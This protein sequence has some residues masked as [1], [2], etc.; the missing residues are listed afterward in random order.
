MRSPILV[1][2][3]LLASLL[4][5]VAMAANCDS[6]NPNYLPQQTVHIFIP[7]VPQVTFDTSGCVTGD[8]DNET[9]FWAAQFPETRQGACDPP[10]PW[11]G[12]HNGG[13]GATATILSNT[14]N[15]PV[16]Y[17]F[18]TDGQ[19][20]AAWAAGVGCTSNGI[21][22]DSYD[23]DPF[24]CGQGITGHFP[25]TSATLAPNPNYHAGSATDPD[26]WATS[27]GPVAQN[28]VRGD[29]NGLDCFGVL[30]GSAW[31]FLDKGATSMPF[32]GAITAP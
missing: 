26:P 20:P 7:G 27:F 32:V 5:A 31:A 4:P 21:I 18:G 28:A 8:G 29:P 30:D 11:S 22:S 25:G 9:G 2:L 19:D 17:T 23:T 10:A 1:A 24:D 14:G 3:L 6:S 13:P 12:H 16:E 15:L